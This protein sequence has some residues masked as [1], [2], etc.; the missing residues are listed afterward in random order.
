MFVLQVGENGFGKKESDRG[1]PTIGNVI[2]L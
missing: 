2:Y 1:I